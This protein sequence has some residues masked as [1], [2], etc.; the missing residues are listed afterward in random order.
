MAST[1]RNHPPTRVPRCD[2]KASERRK[3]KEKSRATTKPIEEN[4]TGRSPVQQRVGTSWKRV[5]RLVGRLTG[6]GVHSE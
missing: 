2:K 1:V 5:L 6:R 4:L 3:S